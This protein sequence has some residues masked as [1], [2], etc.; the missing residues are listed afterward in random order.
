M[1]RVLLL[2]ATIAVACS[3]ARTPA[4]ESRDEIVR[5][6]NRAAEVVR[7]NGAG[8]CTE[9]QR[10]A[11]FTSDWYVFV[12][13]QDGRT[14]CHPARPEMVGRSSNELVD[15]NGKRFGE[16][17]VRTAASG[18]GWVDYMWPRPSS[19]TPEAKSSYVL[20]VSGP[21][22]RTYIVG[23]GGHAVR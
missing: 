17:F 18:G 23:S 2:L 3:T 19:T 15:V 12:L 22:G 8:A 13:D 14:V 6:V 1:N 10:P 5:Y 20:S 16:E 9:L 11:W 4:T 7:V 21:D